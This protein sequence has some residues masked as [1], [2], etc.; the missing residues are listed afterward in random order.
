MI[1]TILQNSRQTS[2]YLDER[3]IAKKH[4]SH[5]SSHIQHLSRQIFIELFNFQIATMWSNSWG[6]TSSPSV[7]TGTSWTMHVQTEDHGDVNRNDAR[8]VHD[9]WFL[10]YR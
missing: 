9:G 6:M 8:H 3:L 2:T 4:N 7:G 10:R 1:A 5:L